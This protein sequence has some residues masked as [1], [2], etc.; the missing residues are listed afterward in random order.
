MNHK[1]YRDKG[2]I[3]NFVSIICIIISLTPF[4]GNKSYLFLGFILSFYGLVW[5]VKYIESVK[6]LSIKSRY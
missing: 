4:G 5:T 6:K 1:E 3:L 2:I